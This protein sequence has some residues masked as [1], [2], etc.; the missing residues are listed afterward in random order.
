MSDRYEVEKCFSI[1]YSTHPCYSCCLFACVFFKW[2]KSSLVRSA[3]E[4]TATPLLSKSLF[5]VFIHFTR[6]Y[7]YH[8]KFSVTNTVSVRICLAL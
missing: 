7:F 1:P 2:Q 6:Q 8:E 5:T 4:Q 3:S